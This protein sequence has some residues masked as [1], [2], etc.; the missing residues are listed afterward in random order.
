MKHKF[1]VKFV[2]IIGLLAISCLGSWNLFFKEYWQ[3]DTVDIHTFP[4]Q[5]DG[6]TS[7]EIPITEDEYAILETD[8]AFARRYT[9]DDGKEVFLFI[10]YSENNRKV[11]HPPEIC[12]SG[13]G[14]TILKKDPHKFH[15]E[16]GA[17]LPVNRLLLE[18]GRT[19]QLA[20]YWFK[21]GREFTPNYWKQQGLVAVKSLLGQPSSSALI[22][23][24]VTVKSED[25]VLAE[26]VV[27]E[28][29]RSIQPFLAQHLP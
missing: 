16:T 13:G 28:F 24:S 2:F 17:D 27:Q 14:I 5:F 18:Q 23:V 3:A 20:F 1:D 12:Y 9:T 21:V 29:S 19:R 6:W 4:K 26:N 8:N 22:R 15:F 7:E 11:S 25:E 10:V